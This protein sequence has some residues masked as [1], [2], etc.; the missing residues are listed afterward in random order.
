MQAEYWRRRKHRT[1]DIT[2]VQYGTDVEGTAFASPDSQD[3]LGSSPWN[4][5][6]RTALIV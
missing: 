2:H 1:T 3:P 5:R 4:M 6:V